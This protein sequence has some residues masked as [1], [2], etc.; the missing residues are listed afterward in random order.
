MDS[1]LFSLKYHDYHSKSIVPCNIEMRRFQEETDRNA[2]TL[3]VRSSRSGQIKPGLR[4]DRSPGLF[5]VE[6]LVSF[7]IQADEW[8]ISAVW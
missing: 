5:Q 6:T 8:I 2:L 7:Y 4:N 1:I 3:I